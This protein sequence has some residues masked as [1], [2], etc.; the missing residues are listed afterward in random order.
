MAKEGLLANV[1]SSFFALIIFF[2]FLLSGIVANIAWLLVFPVWFLS[3]ELYRRCC[4]FISQAWWR[5]A[6]FIP[7]HWCKA[8][9]KL[10]TTDSL[11]ELSSHESVICIANHRYTHDW[12][13]DWIMAEYYGML[14]QC[15]AFVKAVVAKF[16]IL[17]WSM[18]FNEFVF[19]SRSKTGQDLSKI[20]KSMDHLREYSIPVWLLLYPEGTRYTKEKHDQSMEFAKEKGLKTLKHLL[21]PRPKGFHESISCLHNSNVKAVYDCTVVLDGDKDVTVGELL[22]GK[23]FK[24]TVC[25]ARMELDSI[26]TDESECKKY[27]FNLFEEKDK[28]FEKMLTDEGSPQPSEYSLPSSQFY[29]EPM[30]LRSKSLPI[31]PLYTTAIWFFIVM[32]PV[33]NW[34]VSI[35]SSSFS[36]FIV[37]VLILVILNT[38]VSYVLYAFETKKSSQGLKKKDT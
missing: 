25:A 38:G 24:M 34:L 13:L 12:L 21:L 15:K 2:T 30:K 16:P 3:K 26:P 9:V 8:E 20:R 35:A 14:G 33:L 32:L 11:E 10:Y 27:L 17:G 4:K 22:R 7:L 18:W 5:I 29:S 36:A 6:V 28:L 1:R 31:E 19:L 23:P 37:V